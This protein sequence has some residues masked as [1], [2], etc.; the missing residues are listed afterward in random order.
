MFLRKFWKIEIAYSV[1]IYFLET[2]YVSRGMVVIVF[3]DE[4][5]SMKGV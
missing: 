3:Q 1:F 5:K 2:A 4:A